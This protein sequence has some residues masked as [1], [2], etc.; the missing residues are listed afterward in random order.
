MTFVST[1]ATLVALN[2]NSPHPTPTM[3]A[4]KKT[5]QIVINDKETL[6]EMPITISNMYINEFAFETLRLD[7]ESFDGKFRT[8]VFADSMGVR[9]GTIANTY[10]DYNTRIYKNLKINI[11]NNR[12]TI[13]V[14]AEN[15]SR[16]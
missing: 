5:I 13:I 1:L 2:R 15:G 4:P 9:F 3:A 14:D 12:I 6:V 11:I 7:I 10:L 16:T 8:L